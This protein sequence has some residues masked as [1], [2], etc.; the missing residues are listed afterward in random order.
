MGVDGIVIPHMRRREDAERAVSYARFP[1]QGVRGSA[2]NIR[3]AQFGAGK[4]FSWKEFVRKTNEDVV[5][6]GMGEDQAFFENIDDI[7]AVDGLSMIN[8]GPTDLATDM[9]LNVLYDLDAPPIKAALEELTAKAGAR[10]IPVMCP[11]GSP[12]MERV[13]KLMKQGVKCIGLLASQKIYNEACRRAV[14]E[15]ITPIRETK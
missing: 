11:A 1:P 6:I 10:N 7:L 14:E 9:G 2:A 13:R 5:V 3:A 12:S 8:Y 4:N 15:I